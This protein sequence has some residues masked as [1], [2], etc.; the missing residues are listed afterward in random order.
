MLSMWTKHWSPREPASDGRLGALWLLKN[1]DQTFLELLLMRQII[2]LDTTPI[3]G[4]CDIL[5]N[6]SF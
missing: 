4:E 2:I 1:V 5:N 3:N 6:V